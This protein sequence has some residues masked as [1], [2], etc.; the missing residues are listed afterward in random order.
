MHL[1]RETITNLPPVVLHSVF[2]QKLYSDV[3]V[4]HF[5]TLH[6]SQH[7]GKE[8]VTTSDGYP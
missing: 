3:A 6:A 5:P 8:L 4:Y 2:A 7:D 1:E